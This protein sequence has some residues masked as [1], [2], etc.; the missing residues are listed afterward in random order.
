MVRQYE[1]L[2]VYSV[3]VFSLWFKC[4][5]YSDLQDQGYHVETAENLHKVQ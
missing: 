1:Y 5:D 4:F 3:T 2:F